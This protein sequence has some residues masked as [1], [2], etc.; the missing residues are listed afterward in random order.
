LTVIASYTWS[1]T[2]TN[3]ASEFSDFS[4]ADQ[5][6]YNARAQKGLSIN[7]Y[8]QNLVVTYSYELPFGPGKKFLSQGGAAG[9]VVGGWKIAGTQD[10][11]SGPPQGFSEPCN[12]GEGNG[13][14]GNN[15]NG[16]GF[17]CRPNIIAG[18]PLKNPLRNQPGF[19]PTHESLVNP[20][21]F[22]ETPNPSSPGQAGLGYQSYF[23]DMPPMLGGAG[24][25]LPYMDEDISV[26]KRTQVTERVN[27]EFRADFLN[28]FNRTVFG[29][30]SGG[31]MYGTALGNQ[32]GSGP[33]GVM[34]SQSNTPREIQFG[35]KINY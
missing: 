7:D 34:S 1:K 4:G 17:S 24:R 3:A 21:A 14:T 26:I 33:F 15:I 30:G 25:R 13:Y 16:G 23:G 5:D 35:L 11:Q 22:A 9:R 8:P 31:D 6:S 19:D 2:L 32:I 27:I 20:A 18:V 29:T 12:L 28:I 10:Y